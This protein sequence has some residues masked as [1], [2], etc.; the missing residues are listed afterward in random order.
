MPSESNAFR[1]KVCFPLCWSQGWSNMQMN[2]LFEH[3]LICKR[4]MAFVRNGTQR[5][6]VEHETL[7][8]LIFTIRRIEFIRHRHT[9]THAF[10]EF[11]TV[12]GAMNLV[13]NWLCYLGGAHTIMRNEQL[14]RTKIHLNSHIY[15][16]LIMCYLNV[17]DGLA[18]CILIPEI[19]AC[20]PLVSSRQTFLNGRKLVCAAAATPIK[21]IRIAATQKCWQIFRIPKFGRH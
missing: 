6:L 1:K 13:H 7:F 18:C 8:K 9:R 3:H 5:S 20:L 14:T 19:V 17:F 4:N 10:N 12:A 11:K 2:C 16:I 15:G 21:L